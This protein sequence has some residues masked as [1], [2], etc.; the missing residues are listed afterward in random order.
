[1]SYGQIFSGVRFRV[2][3]VISYLPAILYTTVAIFLLWHGRFLAEFRLSMGELNQLP[4]VLPFSSFLS[5]LN[6]SDAFG[7]T[8]FFYLL[9]L[10]GVFIPFGR[11]GDLPISPSDTSEST[12]SSTSS[13]ELSDSLFSSSSAD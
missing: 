6:E 8:Q 7:R 9:I 13:S 11:L 10:R 12:T 3:L 1:L 2:G 5:D 4:G